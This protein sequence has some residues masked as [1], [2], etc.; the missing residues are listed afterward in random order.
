MDK[1]KKILFVANYKPG[2]GGIS[3]QVEYLMKYLPLEENYYAEVFATTGPVSKRIVKFFSLLLK[4]RR[5]D[6]LHLHGCSGHGFL[7]IVYGTV[8]GKLWRKRIVVTYHGGSADAFFSK[9][10]RW[11]RYWL[12]KADQRVVMSGFLK[13]VF[14]KY[15]IPSCVIPNVVKLKDDVYKDR[16]EILPRFLS[17]RHLRSLYNIPCILRAFERVQRQVPEAELVLLGDGDKRMELEEFVARHGLKNVHF[18]G[19]VPNEE[20]GIYYQ[21][22]DVMLSAPK[23]DNMPVSLLEAFSA[24]LLVISSRVGGVPYMVEHGKTGLLFESNND[25][26]MAEMMLWALSHQTESLQMIDNAKRE[27]KQYS[28]ECVREKLLALYE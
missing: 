11:T 14:D 19:Q 26:E 22:S 28:W 10:T 4:A 12:M 20:I 13:S 21:K 1:K 5:F 7:P 8:A 15:G 17:V 9:H 2:I 24:G 18:V 16:K 27:V 3:G 23:A 6:V 25:T